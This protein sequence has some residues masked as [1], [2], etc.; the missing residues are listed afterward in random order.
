MLI[1]ITCTNHI[2]TY[3]YEEQLSTALNMTNFFKDKLGLKAAFVPDYA[4][5]YSDLAF[6]YDANR[7][8]EFYYKEEYKN[9]GNP[10]PL[11]RIVK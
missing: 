6:D 2:D 3:L 11:L 5:M 8:R 9:F 10:A 4:P 1:K 7:Q